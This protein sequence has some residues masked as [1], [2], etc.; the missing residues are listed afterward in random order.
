MDISLLKKLGEIKSFKLNDFIFLEGDLGETMYILIK[1]KVGV[2]INSFMDEPF[3]VNELKTGSFFG[4]MSLIDNMPRSATIIALEDN[5][6]ALEIDK[7]NFDSLIVEDLEL[8]FRIIRTLCERAKNTIEKLPENKKSIIKK[9]ENDEYYKL[10]PVYNKDIFEALV[11]IDKNNIVKFAKYVSTLIRKLDQELADI[12]Y[13]SKAAVINS[14]DFIP[15]QHKVYDFKIE[16]DFDELMLKRK[17]KCP[18]CGHEFEQTQPK[19]RSARVVKI[20][21][22]MR[23]ICE[24]YKQ[25]WYN[26]TTCPECLYSEYSNEFNKLSKIYVKDVEKILGELRTLRGTL[27]LDKLDINTIFMKYYISMICNVSPKMREFKMA[28]SWLILSWLYKDVEDEEMYKYSYK[29][30]FEY[31]NK[32]FSSSISSIPAEEEQ[33][34]FM[35]LGELNRREGNYDEALKLL[36]DVTRFK[37]GNKQIG[38]MARNLLADIKELKKKYE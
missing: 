25:E 2:Y 28:R 18:V 32:V 23:K 22:D 34:L 21:D 15:K 3:I 6:L 24:P 10:I 33:K 31:Y 38:N 7:K 12:E 4:E 9:Y 13:D 11:N 17:M 37:D 5:T 8:S 1:G 29:Q 14:L 35:I 26:I 20:E 27:E 16:D 36:F 30:A 19:F